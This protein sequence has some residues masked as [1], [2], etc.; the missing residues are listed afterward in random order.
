VYFVV[1]GMK[2]H[3][4]AVVH[5]ASISAVNNANIQR[6]RQARSSSLKSNAG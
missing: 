6:R 5:P 3:A 2:Y 1:M 4:A